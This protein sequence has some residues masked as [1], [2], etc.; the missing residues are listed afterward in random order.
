MKTQQKAQVNNKITCSPFPNSKKI[1]VS[2]KMHPEIKIPMREISLTETKLYNGKSENNPSVTVYD[3]SG[4]Y[5]DE[6]FSIDVTKGLPKLRSQWKF[7]RSGKNVS[8]MH[9]A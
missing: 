4:I 6:N 3:T 1:Y 5:T 9:H 8:Q 2:G 7:Q